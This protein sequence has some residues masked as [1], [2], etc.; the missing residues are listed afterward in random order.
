MDREKWLATQRKSFPFNLSLLSIFG[1]CFMGVLLALCHP[2]RN[3]FSDG[4]LILCMLT[5]TLL[6]LVAFYLADKG[7][8]EFKM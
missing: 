8:E 2:A 5:T 7:I 4:N 1:M 3:F 6:S